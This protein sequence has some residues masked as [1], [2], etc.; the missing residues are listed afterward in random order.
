MKA[1]AEVSANPPYVLTSARKK[2]RAAVDEVQSSPIEKP[3][4]DIEDISLPRTA[5]LT[6]ENRNVRQ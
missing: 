4:V 3:A 2:S 1:F 5:P 6:K